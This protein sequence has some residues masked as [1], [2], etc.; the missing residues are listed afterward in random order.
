MLNLTRIKDHRLSIELRLTMNTESLKQISLKH[1]QMLFQTNN[2]K[3]KF[4]NSRLRIGRNL[5]KKILMTTL[6]THSHLYREYTRRT[7]TTRITESIQWNL[8]TDLRS[9]KSTTSCIHFASCQIMIIH[10]LP[11]WRQNWQTR[12][13]QD[14]TTYKLKNLRVKCHSLLKYLNSIIIIAWWL[15]CKLILKTTTFNKR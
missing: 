8:I 12:P 1:Y 7:W 2:S 3:P 5:R 15:R 10:P 4:S 9:K 14:S 13:S 11:N 6:R